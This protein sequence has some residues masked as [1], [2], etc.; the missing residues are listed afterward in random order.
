M[1]SRAGCAW[2][3]LTFLLAAGAQ[4]TFAQVPGPAQA[5][6]LTP[7]DQFVIYE[8]EQ[9]AA[10]R[11]DLHVSRAAR[12]RILGSTPWHP[13][14]ELSDQGTYGW[15]RLGDLVQDATQEYYVA[16][17]VG[18]ATRWISL[19]GGTTINVT[20]EPD[21]IA[22]SAAIASASNFQEIVIPGVPG[23]KAVR[24]LAQLTMG[25][26]IPRRCITLVAGD[27]KNYDRFRVQQPYCWWDESMRAV[28][29]A[30]I[31]DATP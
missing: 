26:P 5:D 14:P 21:H 22:F 3:V 9:S 23:G 7:I 18:G 4:I 20:G 19:G 10:F 8:Y 28:G 12:A 6:P 24:D 1:F 2:I 15:I 25:I 16:K 29:V 17:Y 31:E 11:T 30:W 27:G 13:L